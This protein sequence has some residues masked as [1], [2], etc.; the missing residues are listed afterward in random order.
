M[1]LLEKAYGE[2]TEADKD[3]LRKPLGVNGIPYPEAYRPKG[4]SEVDLAISGSIPLISARPYDEVVGLAY[5]NMAVP[6]MLEFERRIMEKSDLQ[7]KGFFTLVIT[8]PGWGKTEGAENL[9]TIIDDRENPYVFVNCA[10]R[11]LEELLWETVIDL[12]EGYRTALF[13]KMKAGALKPKSKDILEKEFS[14]DALIKDRQGNIIG[15]NE[16]KTA[17]PRVI[18]KDDEGKDIYETPL[19]AFERDIK[20]I[21]LVAEFEEIP[22]QGQNTLGMRKVFNRALEKAMKE[23]LML[24]WDEFAKGVEGSEEPLLEFVQWANGMGKDT[25]TVKS[26]FSVHGQ[27]HTAERVLRRRDRAAGFQIVATAN[28][29]DP[30]FQ[31]SDSSPILSRMDMFSMDEPTQRDW[32]HRTGQFLTGLPLST[33]MA[34]FADTWKSDEDEF[35]EMLLEWRESKAKAEGKEIPVGEALRLREFPKTRDAIEKIAQA[36]FFAKRLI[37]TKSGL[38]ILDVNKQNA[39]RSYDAVRDEI[40][41]GFAAKHPIDPRLLVKRILPEVESGRQAPQIPDAEKGI[42]PVFDRKALRQSA[43]KSASSDPHMMEAEFGTRLQAALERWV[44]ELTANLPDTQKMLID[45]FQQRGVA[46]TLPDQ[47]NTVAS[48]LNQ[49]M[50]AHIGGIKSIVALR[51][52]LAKRMRQSNPSLRGSTDNDLI[53]M[54]EAAALCEQLS[55]LPANDSASPNVGRIVTLGNDAKNAFNQA[56]AIDGIATERHKPKKPAASQL[57]R[58]SD[59]LDTLKVPTLANINMR[60]IWRKTLSN[61]NI[62]P[63]NDAYAQLAQIAEG[64]HKS[65]IGITTVMTQN[66]NGEAAPMNVM[67]DGERKK[68]LIVADSVDAETKAALGK[69]YT[70]VSF[71]DKD[72]EEQVAAFIRDTLRHGTRRDQ[73]A[74][75]EGQLA[76]AFLFRAGDTANTQTL[77]KMMSRKDT[78]AKAPVYMVQQLG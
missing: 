1:S 27:N 20:V 50:F 23:G 51:E 11:N 76:A 33:H 77:A 24:I 62:L 14:S 35:R 73:S 63:R 17:T 59:F 64:T 52:I 21:R 4:Q 18:G 43:A 10:G 75:L 32:E 58:V 70:V 78:Q 72:A 44:L 16:D 49:D 60:S 36:I 5:S 55:R 3:R 40:P 74:E 2:L 13:E 53:P 66:D 7:S 30:M 42:K 6:S 45:E 68:S 46:F 67:I 41:P 12:G 15:I 69:D 54:D 65:K 37:D 29:E 71:G 57:V 61:D 48:L 25:I 28:P 39:A 31:Q 19:E 8:P 56:A 26:T 38:H 22:T 47:K 9:S 34:F